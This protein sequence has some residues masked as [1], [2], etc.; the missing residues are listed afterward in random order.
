MRILNEKPTMDRV[1][2]EV[3]GVTKSVV[4]FYIQI[5]LLGAKMQKWNAPL[6]NMFENTQS[7]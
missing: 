6:N 3:H 4:N 5:V 7:I 1:D 2:K